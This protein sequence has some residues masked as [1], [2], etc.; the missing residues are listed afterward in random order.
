MAD[1]V[2]IAFC[3][4]PDSNVARQA[5]HHVVERRLAA[6]GNIL[7][8][9]HSIYQW[10]GKIESGEEILVIFK[11][12]RHRYAEFES[13]IRSMHPYQVP[14]IIAFPLSHGLPAYL[15][16]VRSSCT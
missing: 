10:Q 8:A 4:F 6:C 14:E 5:T 12:D 2:L 13:A 3:T 1:N 16:W 9:I 7:P 15:E 11:L